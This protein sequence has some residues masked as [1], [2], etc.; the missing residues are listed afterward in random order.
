M[1][2]TP[3][4][5]HVRTYTNV[6]RALTDQGH[7]T[8]VC[9]PQFMLDAN[10]VD[11]HGTKIIAYG[12]YLKNSEDVLFGKILDKFWRGESGGV[13]DFIALVKKMQSVIRQILSDKLLMKQIKDL[14]PDLLVLSNFAPFRNFVMI[15][16]IMD[17]PFVY[18]GPHNDL[19]GQRVPFSPSSVPCPFHQGFS[20]RGMSFVDRLKTA[21]CNLLVIAVDYYFMDDKMV[22]EFAPHRPRA[23]VGE[24]SRRAQLY[25][26][27]SD[28][29]L[30][31]PKPE[32]PNMKLIGSTAVSLPRP[33]GEPFRS[34]VEGSRAGIAVV[35]FGTSVLAI[36][37]AVSQ[38]M[39]SAFLQQELDVVW[40][41]NV[42]SAHP[43]RIMT[44]HW[45]PQNDLLAHPKTKLFVSHCGTN[46]QYEALYHAVPI[47]CLPLIGEQLYNSHRSKSKGFGLT[48]S[49]LD[50]SDKRLAR[51]MR[52]VAESDK[53][54]GSIKRA[55]EFFRM[56]YKAPDQAAAF[57]INHVM[58][59]GGRYMKSAAQD[60]PVYQFLV[61]DGFGVVVA[62]IV[63]V[64][65]VLSLLCW[66]GCR[67][68]RRVSGKFWQRV[69]FKGE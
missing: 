39:I 29:I 49:I 12:R 58:E 53:Y 34:F 43:D 26:I 35:S 20:E 47:L 61:L 59:H 41:A 10:L 66:C 30:D 24:I 67:A 52:R 15:S 51:L 48:A 38:K 21:A 40:R 13:T 56:L 62:T 63:I 31:F 42:S 65:A 25:I 6:A 45:L 7:T 68:L 57:W 16:H 22:Q 5:S 4:T 46:G 2:S 64:V 14:K 69:K 33:L 17:V 28:H 32:L 60:M 36:P 18:L 44:S 11:T 27:E 37:K 23:S 9:V 55:S 1:F 19:A 3:H 54:R 8:Y 50:I